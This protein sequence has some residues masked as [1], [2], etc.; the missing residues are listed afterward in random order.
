MEFLSFPQDTDVGYFLFHPNYHLNHYI[1]NQ[2]KVIIKQYLT[3]YVYILPF[4]LSQNWSF[5]LDF[6]V[7][8]LA[9]L[10]LIIKYTYNIIQYTISYQ[11]M[12]AKTS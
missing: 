5:V 4:Q 7:Q 8:V 3:Y 6:C 2:L 12:L 9:I 1:S 11:L 10:L